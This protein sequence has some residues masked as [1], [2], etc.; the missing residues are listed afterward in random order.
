MGVSELVVMVQFTKEEFG[1]NTDLDDKWRQMARKLLN[2]NDKT[3]EALLEEFEAEIASCEDLEELT[4][5]DIL[6]DRQFLIRYLRGAN[7]NVKTGLDLFTSSFTQVKDYFPYMSAGIP[8]ELDKVWSQELFAIP[9]ERD[10]HARRVFIFRLGQW[11]PTVTSSQELFTAAFTLFELIA[12][13]ERTQIAGITIVLDVSGFGFQHLKYLGIN[14]LRCLC[15]FL[16]GAFP[17]WMRRIHIVNN[18]RIFNL[19]INLCKPFVTDR[20]RENIVTHGYDLH[21]LHCEVSPSLLPKYLGGAQDR[22]MKKCVEKAKQL[23]GHF[24]K[25]IKNARQIYARSAGED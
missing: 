2:E 14:E 3:T 7:W 24:L 11:N 22:E 18:P 23:D 19:F 6:T 10:Q 4:D 12:M 16:T 13:E 21:S 5:N 20:V 9:E 15:N 8:S 17:I 25:N 1:E